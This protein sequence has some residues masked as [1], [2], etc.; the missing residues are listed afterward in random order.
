MYS[1]Y[2]QLHRKTMHKVIKMGCQ[3]MRLICVLRLGTG[4]GLLLGML[5]GLLVG[6][7]G[8]LVGWPV[9]RFDG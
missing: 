3:G 2:P 9:G 8:I 1:R 6:L 4:V 5:L 7:V